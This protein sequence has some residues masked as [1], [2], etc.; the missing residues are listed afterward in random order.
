VQNARIAVFVE[1]SLEILHH[2]NIVKNARNVLFVE[3]L[4]VY[5]KCTA[6]QVMLC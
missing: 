3:I 5:K 4:W 6:V 2:L 1:I